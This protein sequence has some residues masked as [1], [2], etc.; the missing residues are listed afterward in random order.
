MRHTANVQGITSA[1]LLAVIVL[2]VSASLPRG[3]QLQIKSAKPSEKVSN[4][5]HRP[6]Y[7]TK[8]F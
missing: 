3:P 7:P 8:F 6:S 2:F 1:L 5:P 4:D